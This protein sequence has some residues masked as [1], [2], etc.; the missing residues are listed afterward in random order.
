[1]ATVTDDSRSRLFAALRAEGMTEVPEGF[2]VAPV[3]Q[4]IPAAVL[5]EID[6]FLEVFERVTTRA[7]WQRGV[8]ASAPGIARQPRREVCFFSAWDVHLPPGAPE[9]WQLI[10]C[11]DN[12]SGF[13]FAA[14]INH[15]VFALSGLAARGSLEPPPTMA[16]FRGYLAGL[17]AREAAG[18]P[19][20]ET[21]ALTLILDDPESLVHGKFRD[22][23]LLL[24]DLLR[25]QGRD[26]EIAPPGALAWSGRELL[27]NGRRVSF[28]VNR[29]TD[30]HWQGEA[31]AA[32]REAW[33]EGNV[34]MAPN[35]FSHA[36]RSDKRLLE[37]LSCPERDGELGVR[38][39][40]R[41]LLSA[42]VPETRLVTEET[43]EEL[44]RRKEEF[45]FKPACG[46]ASRGLLPSDQVG[47]SRLRR[48][49]RRGDAYVAQRRVARMP[50]PLPDAAGGGPLWADLRVWAYRGERYLLSGRGSRREDGLDLRPP[51]GWLATYALR[52]SPWV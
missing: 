44:V 8:S 5:A 18:L 47:R 15:H 31:F 7:S 17:I 10:E 9:R 38:P 43:L 30:F 21:G 19:A 1:M 45:V 16:A 39:E 12:G 2:S 4:E 20:A 34:Y 37:A 27:L 46:H 22:E 3:H 32:L 23:L 51:G 28:V 33:P 48:L 26:A 25:Q 42:H 13:L 36:T 52:G 11:N 14:L 49:L 40:E 24:R 41:A 50:L 35:P 6:L 29:S